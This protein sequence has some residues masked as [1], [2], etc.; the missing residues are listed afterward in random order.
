MTRP[1]VWLLALAVVLF[2]LGSAQGW[3]MLHTLAYSLLLIIVLSYAWSWWSVRGIYLRPRPKLFRSQVGSYLRERMEIENLSWLPKPWLELHDASDHPEHNLSQVL[4][5]GPLGRH[6]EE[7][8]TGCRQRGQF[9]LGPIWLASGDP[10]GLFP[11]E[12]QV[13]GPSTLVVLPATVQLPS[14]GRLPGELPGGSLQGERVHFTTPNVATV[15][16][17]QPGDSYNRLHWPSTARLGKLVVKEFELDPFSDVW[18]VLDLDRRIQVGLDEDSTEEYAVT[19]AASLARHFLV[20]ERAVG[21]VTQGH[22]LP[23]DRGPRQLLR[24]LEVLAVARPHRGQ[25]L[26]ELLLAQAQSFG[27]GDNAIVVTAA[28]DSGWIA[29]CRDLALRGVRFSAILLDGS[30]FGAAPSNAALVEELSAPGV[31]T[32]VVRHGAD[33]A[34]CLSQPALARTPSPFLTASG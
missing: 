32:Y 19:A 6:V 10:F 14:F 11:R 18:I 23:A 29:I 28:A 24:I 34:A 5:L 27:R 8:R 20:R 22:R 2:A 12:R 9:T 13:F 16:D 7:V 4:S 33:L 26:E 31:P 30:T 21:I 15:R 1:V 25:S 3:G 17:Y